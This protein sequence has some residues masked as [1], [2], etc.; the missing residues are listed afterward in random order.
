MKLATIFFINLGRIKVENLEFFYKKINKMKKKIDKLEEG[1][2]QAEQAAKVKTEQELAN[3]KMIRISVDRFEALEN[4][5]SAAQYQIR[6]ERVKVGELVK[7]NDDLYL[8]LEESRVR[9]YDSGQ[10]LR[11]LELKLE[12][13]R[14]SNYYLLQE[15][16]K[17]G[18]ELAE[19]K[20]EAADKPNKRVG[21][22][23]VYPDL[24]ITHVY[25]SK[26]RADIYAG[27]N[28]IECVRIEY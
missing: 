16:N 1:L 2:V 15:I 7:E 28:R 21:W 12:E 8:S 20:K 6:K 19:L 17:I 24:K 5:L 26:E 14:T 11:Q 27:S 10:M 25:T 4:E 18:V 9:A 13:S 3:S 23:N 22:I